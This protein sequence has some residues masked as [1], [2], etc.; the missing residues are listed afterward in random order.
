MTRRILGI[1][2]NFNVVPLRAIFELEDV[3]L[4]RDAMQSDT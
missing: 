4:K 1:G 3:T 2:P